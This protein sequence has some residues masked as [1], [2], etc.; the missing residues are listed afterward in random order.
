MTQMLVSFLGI[1]GSYSYQAARSFFPE[2]KFLGYRSFAEIIESVQN[3]DSNAA[4]IPVENSITGRIPDVHRLLL[5]MQL[6]IVGELMLPIE[7]CLI[8]SRQGLQLITDHS[9]IRKLL[10]H[11]QGF[12]Q[13]KPYINKHFPDADLVDISDTANAVREVAQSEDPTVAA[14]GPEVAAEIY[15][16]VVIEKNIAAI[17]DNYTRF[18]LLSGSR[19]PETDEAAD[20]TTLIFQVR[21]EPGALLDALAVFQIEGINL[22]KLETYTIAKQTALPTFYIDVGAGLREERMQ[23][24]LQNLE[25]RA[26]YV[27]ILGSYQSSSVRKAMS[28]FL[29]THPI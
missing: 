21:H 13:C 9:E 16:A 17:E 3:Q 28:G 2:A 20:M 5:S 8:R 22:T 4:V 24:A 26:K 6:T 25:I 1:D 18:V 27:K 15:D 14:I 10:S 7:H 12:M 23:R 19:M 11:P 29:P